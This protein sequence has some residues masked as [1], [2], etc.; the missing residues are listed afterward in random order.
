[1]RPNETVAI[2]VDCCF[3]P[4]LAELTSR[5]M[6]VWVSDT[7]DNRVFVEELLSL[8]HAPGPNLTTFKAYAEESPEEALIRILPT[9]DIHHNELAGDPPYRAVEV[10]GASAT[11]S[12]RRALNE[13]ALTVVQEDGTHFRAE[14][15]P[16]A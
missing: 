4:R 1:M 7:S 3:G 11:S 12:V 10:F 15:I 6:A 9:V 16:S 2:V 13:F 5:G 14:A 8:P